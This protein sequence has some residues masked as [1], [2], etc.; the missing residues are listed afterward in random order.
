MRPLGRRCATISKGESHTDI[1]IA[2]NAHLRKRRESHGLSN[3]SVSRPN[4]SP[5]LSATQ[6]KREMSARWLDETD[7]TCEDLESS[8]PV[9][10]LSEDSWLRYELR[11]D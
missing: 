9:G 11:F 7:P 5:L 1:P 10:N 3:N 8:L 2:G 6:S 4:F